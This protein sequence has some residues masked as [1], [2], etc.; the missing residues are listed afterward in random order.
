[1]FPLFEG[2]LRLLTTTTKKNPYN[3]MINK[4]LG[5]HVIGKVCLNLLNMVRC[6]L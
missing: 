4:T 1:M 6:M 2:L 5:K 3:M